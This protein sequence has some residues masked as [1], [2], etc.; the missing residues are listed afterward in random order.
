MK[1]KIVL[2]VMGVLFLST[3]AMAQRNYDN[4]GGYCDGNRNGNH[5]GYY[6]N[7]NLSDAEY[8]K[9]REQHRQYRNSEYNRGNHRN[10]SNRGNHMSRNN[11]R[12]HNG[13][14]YHMRGNHRGNGRMH[15]NNW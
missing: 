4:Y 3:G 2:T 1:K 12:N 10:Y 5:M 7:S 9:M 11:Y 13:N 14:G 8:N 6:N 15:N